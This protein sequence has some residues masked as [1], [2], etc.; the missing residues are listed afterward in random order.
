[1]FK[2][3]FVSN[4]FAIAIAIALIH[5]NNMKLTTTIDEDECAYGTDNCDPILAEC[6]NIVGGYLCECILGYEGSGYEGMCNGKCNQTPQINCMRM[7][8]FPRF[9]VKLPCK[10]LLYI[11][12]C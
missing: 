8:C 11:F 7:K 1:M 12:R 5:L 6:V 3:R 4:L 9:P 10:D 2:K